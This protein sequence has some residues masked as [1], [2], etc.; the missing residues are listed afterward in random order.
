MA[1]VSKIL[2]NI[3]TGNWLGKE[4]KPANMYYVLFVVLL[5]IFLIYNRYRA[6]E[7]I[8]EKRALKE[9]VEI[10]HSKYTKIDTKLMILGTERKVAKDSTVIKLGLKLPENPPK[11]III[12][13]IN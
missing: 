7:M 5:V 2:R 1:R 8:V 4:V 9:E 3:L 10:L 13:K 6:E 12:E 11:Q